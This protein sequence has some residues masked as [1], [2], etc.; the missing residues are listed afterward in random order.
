MDNNPK[1]DLVAVTTLR[2]TPEPSQ[3]VFAAL[4][5]DYSHEP[6]RNLVLPPEKDC[7]KR[8]IENLLTGNKGH[9]GP[10]E[11]PHITVATEFFP[12]STMQQIRT[13]R[14]AISVDCQSFRYTSKG[15]ESVVGGLDQDLDQIVIET[16]DNGCQKV[17]GGED[18]HKIFYLS[19]VGTYRDRS[20]SKWVYSEAERQEDLLYCI[21]SAK[22]YTRKRQQGCPPER[23]RSII[24]FDVRQH[25]VLTVNARS[26]MHLLDLRWKADAQLECQWFASLLFDR[27]SEWMPE[28][29]SWYSEARGK[30]AILS[31]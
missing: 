11:H 9:F 30:K 10:L 29:A 27:F 1:D 13:H 6:V 28:V 20:G 25:W 19:P 5:Q 4:R 3:L 14:V 21:E 16:L 15:V 7:G 26:L 31:P 12:H 24:P 18:P 23:A 17:A 22:R 8:V 2:S